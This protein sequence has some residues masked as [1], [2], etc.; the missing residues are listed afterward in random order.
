MKGYRN[1]A[2]GFNSK[3]RSFHVDFASRGNAERDAPTAPRPTPR[4]LSV[5]YIYAGGKRYAAYDANQLVDALSDL[6]RN[7]RPQ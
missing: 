3:N 7:G 4:E 1:A 5:R 6:E 2:L